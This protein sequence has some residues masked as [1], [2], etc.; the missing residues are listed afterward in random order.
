MCWVVCCLSWF[1]QLIFRTQKAE[2]LPRNWHM[3]VIHL[4][5][6]SAQTL[7]IGVL[8]FLMRRNN[9][10]STLIFQR[11]SSLTNGRNS[12]GA[13]WLNAHSPGSTIPDGSVKIM[14]FPSPPLRQ[15]S[16]FLISTLYSNAYE[17]NFLNGFAELP[18]DMTSWLLPFSPSST[19][20]PLL[21]Y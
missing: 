4:S 19:W 11:K 16:K 12:L 8:S 10:V 15:W 9:L 17:Y 18:P 20:P 21:F 14:R 3:S 1:M 7:D 5:R 2:Y 13:G 6:N